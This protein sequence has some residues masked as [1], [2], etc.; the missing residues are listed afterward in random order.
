M[1]SG[2]RVYTGFAQWARNSK[3]C[4]TIPLFWSIFCAWSPCKNIFKLKS[5]HWLHNMS[6]TYNFWAI[7][8]LFNWSKWNLDLRLPFLAKKCCRKVVLIFFHP[9]VFYYFYYSIYNFG[10]TNSI[11]LNKSVDR[12]I[13]SRMKIKWK[14]N[15]ISCLGQKRKFQV[16]FDHVNNVLITPILCIKDSFDFLNRFLGSSQL[17]SVG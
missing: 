5:M 15:S 2:S 13:A 9:S 8:T 4:S 17:C 3:F 16:H 12:K 1:A 14:I 11:S 6:L 7:Q 10:Q